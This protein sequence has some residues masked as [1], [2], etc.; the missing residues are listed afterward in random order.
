MK[1]REEGSEDRVTGGKEERDVRVHKKSAQFLSLLPSF[2]P[3]LIPFPPHLCTDNGKVHTPCG[4]SSRPLPLL[5][6]GHQ[7]HSST[8]PNAIGEG[9]RVG[10]GGGG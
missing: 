3:S 4:E 10:G 7:P 9:G 2:Y 8:I 1:R 5:L 6:H